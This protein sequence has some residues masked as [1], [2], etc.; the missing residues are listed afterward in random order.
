M[1]HN[2]PNAYFA[3]QGNTLNIRVL[4]IGALMKAQYITSSAGT[5]SVICAPVMHLEQ[6]AA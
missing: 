3:L 4:V 5:E 1:Q 2:I 6:N